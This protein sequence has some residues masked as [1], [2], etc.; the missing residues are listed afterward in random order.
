METTLTG[1]PLIET[2]NVGINFSMVP[3]RS[4]I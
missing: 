4:R 2:N 3:T 1:R